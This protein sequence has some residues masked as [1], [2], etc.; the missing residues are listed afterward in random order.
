M[1]HLSGDRFMWDLRDKNIS[2]Q[3]FFWVAVFQ[4]L[5]AV[6][7]ELEKPTYEAFKRIKRKP[8]CDGNWS[9][10]RCEP[11]G[12]VGFLQEQFPDLPTSWKCVWLS[13][14]R[15]ESTIK[16]ATVLLDYFPPAPSNHLPLKKTQLL[17]RIVF[18]ILD[19]YSLTSVQSFT[20]TIWKCNQGVK[21][22]LA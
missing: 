15:A 3:S 10:G 13:L 4:D 18:N 2:I 1:N 7:A 11:L 16:E 14:L 21:L 17:E 20:R 9:G 22:S 19:E 5:S 12:S 6:S 8:P